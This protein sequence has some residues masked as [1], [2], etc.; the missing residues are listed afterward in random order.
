[1]SG[2]RRYTIDVLRRLA[3]IDVTQRAGCTLAEIGDLLGTGDDPA[4]ERVR[5]LAERRLPEIEALIRRAEAVHRWLEMARAC[6]CDTLDI[7]SLFDDRALGL[8]DVPPGQHGGRPCHP[9]P[10]PPPLS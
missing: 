6:E 2:R 4:Y 9:R 5:A 10:L 1:V 8:A 7:C 3:I